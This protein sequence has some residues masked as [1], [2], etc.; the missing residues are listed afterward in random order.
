[1][2]QAYRL[3]SA[4]LCNNARAKLIRLLNCHQVHLVGETGFWL[5]H[6]QENGDEDVHFYQFG[7][8]KQ[9]G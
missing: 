9:H 3:Q 4:D 8:V 5:I 2:T 7:L 1:M 6:M